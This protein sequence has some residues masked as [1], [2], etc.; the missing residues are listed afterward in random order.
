MRRNVTKNL[1][2]LLENKGFKDEIMADIDLLQLCPNEV[3]FNKALTLF[4]KKW[5]TTKK[6]NQFIEYMDTQWLSTHRNWYEGAAPFT[7]STNNS[8]ESFN[9]VIKKEIT[10]RERSHFPVSLT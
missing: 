8:L 10:F 7:P 3:I 4:K 6:E 9:L 1:G 5:N 2:S